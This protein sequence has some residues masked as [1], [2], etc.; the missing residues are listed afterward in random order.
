MRFF[1]LFRLY[2]IGVCR[3]VIWAAVLVAL[4]FCSYCSIRLIGLAFHWVNENWFDGNE[5]FWLI[6]SALAVM[7]VG[8]LLQAAKMLLFR[9][10]QVRHGAGPQPPSLLP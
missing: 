2:F 4:L 10:K 9:R 5:G 6:V 1:D 7:V 3:M 8:M